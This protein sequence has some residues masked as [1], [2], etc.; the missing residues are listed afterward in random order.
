M[1]TTYFRQPIFV[2]IV[3]VFNLYFQG[4]IFESNIH[5]QVHVKCDGRMARRTE[6][7]T[8]LSRGVSPA[9]PLRLCVGICMHVIFVC[10]SVCI[11]V[12]VS[13]SKSVTGRVKITNS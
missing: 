5:S 4:H 2:Q 12:Y 1:L 8:K 3:N 6:S 13:V 9:Y 11:C 10:T 7:I